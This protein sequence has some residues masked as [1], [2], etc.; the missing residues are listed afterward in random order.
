MTL[1]A[2]T[3]LETSPAVRKLIGRLRP[4]GSGVFNALTGPGGFLLRQHS[5]VKT[6]KH[7]ASS[8]VTLEFWNAGHRK[9]H[10]EALPTLCHPASWVSMDNAHNPTSGHPL[11][12]LG[13]DLTWEPEDDFFFNQVINFEDSAAY[14]GS[15]SDNV[16][17][18]IEQ[19]FEASDRKWHSPKPFECVPSF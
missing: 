15:Q 11:G 16:T 12:N 2:A 5:I 9:P 14:S 3:C 4:W 10:S 1:E 19:T 6:I 8:I 18:P 13:E 17:S 7:V